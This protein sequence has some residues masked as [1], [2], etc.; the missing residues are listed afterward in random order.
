[1]TNLTFGLDEKKLSEK[2]RIFYKNLRKKAIF[3][4]DDQLRVY[5]N[6]SLAAHEAGVGADGF[7]GGAGGEQIAT[8]IENVPA[9]RLQQH[10]LLS[11]LE[12]SFHPFLVPH[13]LQ[14]HEAIAQTGKGRHEHQPQHQQSLI[15]KRLEHR[16]SYRAPVPIGSSSDGVTGG[17][18]NHFLPCPERI[19][20]NAFRSF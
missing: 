3:A 11:I 14:V 4:A 17:G 6:A 15:L 7:Y 12:G 10:F 18:K 2:D 13:E 20:F 16:K 8:G 1:M 19:W 9:A 5:P